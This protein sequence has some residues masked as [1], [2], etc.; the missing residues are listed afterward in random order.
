MLLLIAI[1]A[2]ALG[3]IAGLFL[4]RRLRRASQPHRPPEVLDMSVREQG[5][6]VTAELPTP[7]SPLSWLDYLRQ[8]LRWRTALV[9]ALAIIVVGTA[10]YTLIQSILGRPSERFLVVV[11]PFDDGGDGRSGRNVAVALAR[12]LR[13]ASEGAIAIRV[14]ERRPTSTPE[15]LALAAELDADVLIWGAVGPG[16]LLDSPS[17]MPRMIYQPTGPYGPNGWDGYLGRFAMPRSYTLAREPI[18]GRATLVPLIVALEAY[19]RG[20]PDRAFAILGRLLE[21]YPSLDETLPRALRGN[22]LWARTLYAAAAEEYR[23]A[24]SGAT[25]EAALLANNLGAVLLDANDPAALDAFAEAVRLLN[26]RDLGELR[27]NLALLA[28]RE[29]RPHDAATQLE[30]ARNLLPHHAELFL[31]LAGAYR[32]SG[33]LDDAAEALDTAR[34]L[35][36][37]DA[38][39]APEP[40][41]PMLLQ[42]LEARLLEEQALLDVARRV[43]AQGPLLW[44]LEISPV[45]PSAELDEAHGRLGRA[46]EISA[47]EAASWKQRAVVD[48]AGI[49]EAGLV[50]SGQAERARLHADRQQFYRAVVEMERS[51][52]R[53]TRSS[54]AL[55]ALFASVQTRASHIAALE[56]LRQRHPGDPRITAA[57][58]RAWRLAGD[59]AAAEQAYAQTVRLAPQA[60]EGYFGQGAVAR[61]RNDMQ[62]AVA[63]YTRALER[64]SAF[65]PAY[66]ELA[67][68]AEVQGDLEGSAAQYRLLHERHP[69]PQSAIALA[70]VLRQLGPEAYAEAERVLSPYWGI[71][72]AAMVELGMLYEAAGKPEAAREAYVQAMQHDPRSTQAAFALGRLAAAD[73]DYQMAARR[74]RQA[75]RN[76]ERNI[77]ARLALADLYYGPL[78][79]P[80]QAER[81]YRRAL[82]QGIDDPTKLA[83]IGDAALARGQHELALEA[84]RA[85][86][87]L[88]PANAVYQ[89]QLSRVAFAAGRRNL[90]AEAA[91]AVLSLTADLSMPTNVELRAEALVTIGDVQRLNGELNAA[92]SSYAQAA[93][94]NPNLIKA[95]IGL[96]LIA[97]GQ[98]NWGIATGYFRTAAGLPGGWD[99]P[100]AQFWLGEALLRQGDYS[101]AEMAYRRALELQPVFPEAELGLAQLYRARG[102]LTE[103]QDHVERALAQRPDYAEAL[104]FK[105]KLSQELGRHDEAW[106]AYNASIRANDQIAETYYRRAILAMQMNRT[107]RAIGDLRRAVQLQPNFPEA[108]YWLGRAYYAQGRLQPALSSFQQALALNAGYVDA[109]FFMGLVYEDM[110]RTADAISAYQTVISIDPNSFFA[111]KARNQ[112]GRLTGSVMSYPA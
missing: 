57:L 67:T 70:R 76:D 111:S 52:A 11:T 30:Q 49:G 27:V 69:S 53:T 21:D 22:V 55:A 18:N 9:V 24:L 28:L 90:A 25:D 65:F 109:A 98:G 43:A 97:V 60:P 46:M 105:G 37:S 112:L 1:I 79:D 63:W 39:L 62:Q 23:R 72:V 87:A 74:F 75:L 7:Q 80:R 71:D 96:G 51:R 91:Q 4:W 42:R 86:V 13:Q 6:K 33:R 64:N 36:G 31:A 29:N 81:E 83:A 108:H 82:E 77:A 66:I 78:N 8:Q 92:A 14:T 5:G 15:A 95:S 26:G 110:G 59:L 12:E 10:G 101:G 103:A 56:A 104:L 2:L 3:V 58:G 107:D 45:L 88:Q 20:Q 61:A 17:L 93:Q 85:A 41:R 100:L 73:G 34:R 47:R 16:A 89:H 50:A 84:Y 106:T 48:G 68:I 19:A 32:E 54:S 94:L 44:E 40:Y 38:R 99:D 35:R 102:N